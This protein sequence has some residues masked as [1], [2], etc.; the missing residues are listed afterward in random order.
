MKNGV[1]YEKNMKKKHAVFSIFNVPLL[2]FINEIFLKNSKPL[3]KHV[4]SNTSFFVLQGVYI[5]NWEQNYRAL[6]YINNN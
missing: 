2:F 3:W 5:I 1:A 6:G 4:L